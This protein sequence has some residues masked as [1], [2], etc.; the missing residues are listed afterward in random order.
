MSLVPWTTL[1]PNVCEDMIAVMVC[2]ENPRT[3]RIRPSQG[4]GGIDLIRITQAGWVVDQIKYFS[5]NLTSGQKAQIRNSFAELRKFAASKGA[6]IA[7]WRLVIPLDPTK[8]NYLE[9]FEQEVTH[10]ADFPCE[11]RGLSY[12]EGLAGTYPEV[13]DYCIGNGKSRVEELIAQMV[14]AFGLVNQSSQV[15]QSGQLQPLDTVE[16]LE[17]IYKAL[18][19]HDPHYRYSFAV[20]HERPALRLDEPY[21]AATQ[22]ETDMAWVTFKMYARFDDA[23]YVRPIPITLTATVPEGS[24]AAQ[25]LEDFGKFGSP[26]SV[27]SGQGVDL[28]VSVDLP[29]GLGGV[30]TSGTVAFVPPLAPYDASGDLRMQ[31]LDEDGREIAVARLKRTEITAG[32]TGEGMRWAGAE[33]HGVFEIEMRADLTDQTSTI[34]LQGHDLTGLRPAEALAG[35][36]VVAA[37]RAPNLVRFA[38]PYGPVTHAGI[39]ITIGDAEPA[40]SLDGI[41]KV[42]EAMAIIQEHTPIQITMPSIGEIS[43]EF[44]TELV[45]IAHLLH[46]GQIESTWSDCAFTVPARSIPAEPDFDATGPLTNAEP[47]IAR[48]GGLEVPL[49]SLRYHCS[50]ARLESIT[51]LSEG[52]VRV[53]LVPGATANVLIQHVPTASLAASA[54]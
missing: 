1:D 28:T 20:D 53:T 11:W 34:V 26:L 16:G 31:I 10:D 9:W 13:V 32:P 21:L 41:V 29:G 48:I 3:V 40:P 30:H 46:A 50:S 36:R 39:P 45:W 37:F 19:A 25:A 52:Q 5:S 17:A 8:E 12:V 47:L 4:D 24:A 27:T 35:V 23:V 22:I 51:A 7:E 14:T 15:A 42:V 2:R 6:H 38:L 18:N 43:D 44:G 33:E 49:G 54:E